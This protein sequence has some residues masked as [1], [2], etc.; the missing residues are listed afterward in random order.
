MIN[1]DDDDNNNNNNN[2]N[3][4]SNSNNTRVKRYVYTFIDNK[5]NINNTT[6]TTLQTE[7]QKIYGKRKVWRRRQKT[8]FQNAKGQIKFHKPSLA[9]F[10]QSCI[11]S[12]SHRSDW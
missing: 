5:N 2:N 3:N 10:N 11:A 4:N 1:N 6:L 9:T 7:V 8:G 12:P